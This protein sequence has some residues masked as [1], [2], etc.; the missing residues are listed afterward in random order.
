MAFQVRLAVRRLVG[1]FHLTF[2][3]ELGTT[4]LDGADIGIES[5]Q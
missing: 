5:F 3:R 2:A 4:H 1:F